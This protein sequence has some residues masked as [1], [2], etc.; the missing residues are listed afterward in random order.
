MQGSSSEWVGWVGILVGA[1]SLRTGTRSTVWG[2]PLM[3]KGTC[4]YR[5]ESRRYDTLSPLSVIVFPCFL[6]CSSVSLRYQE[7]PS[8]SIIWTRLSLWIFSRISDSKKHSPNKYIPNGG[9]SDTTWERHSC[10]VKCLFG[11]LEATFLG[12]VI[13]STYKYSHESCIVFPP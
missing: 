3:G 11:F 6:R 1:E 9:P 4:S 12:V 8:M 10:V 5:R 7:V 2:L 13:C